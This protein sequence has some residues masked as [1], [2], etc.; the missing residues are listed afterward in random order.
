[1]DTPPV[2]R[3]PSRSWTRR[4]PVL[5][6]AIL[7]VAGLLATAPPTTA[8]TTGTVPQGL[9]YDVV[10]GWTVV[11][12]REASYGSGS[13]AE[14]FDFDG[15]ALA[16]VQWTF[17]SGSAQV[18]QDPYNGDWLFQ[19]QGTTPVVARPSAGG[20]LGDPVE[21]GIA[22]SLIPSDQGDFLAA[23]GG[24]C[25]AN[26]NHSGL[27]AVVG[28]EFEVDVRSVVDTSVQPLSASE[29]TL[30]YQHA[31]YH[32]WSPEAGP[33][34]V[35]FNPAYV[36]RTTLF[37]DPAASDPSQ[38][39]FPAS[40]ETD[41]HFIIDFLDHGI[42][43]FNKEPMRLR[44]ASTDWPPFR[45]PQ[46]NDEGD[47]TEFYMVGQPDVLMMTI[48]SQEQYVYPT[49]ELA[50]TSS[51]ATIDGQGL[52]HVSFDIENVSTQQG[53]VRWFVLGDSG[54]PQTPREGVVDLAAG[55]VHRVDFTTRPD[56]RLLTQFVTLGAVTETGPR[57]T[58][59]ARVEFLFPQ[60]SALRN[61]L[62]AE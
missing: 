28:P 14:T 34:R 5:L 2:T 21:I 41:L 18:V 27:F 52:L 58:G 53:R 11:A 50:I 47:V 17:D 24:A 15:P 38:P 1:M 7:S 30:V 42:S 32:A 36:S 25:I 57:L 62:L 10:D 54:D 16:N 59:S 26:P 33:M 43:V 46:V 22:Q 6:A 44:S 48:R 31:Q 55:A 39:F 29:R 4:A 40:A 9:A 3:R 60:N 56:E 51:G 35:R 19:P 49:T 8:Q 61:T 37:G 20:V 23:G 45:V 13:G 12:V